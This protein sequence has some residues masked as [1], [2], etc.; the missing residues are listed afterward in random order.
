MLNIPTR[1]LNQNATLTRRSRSN[2]AFASE[3]STG[4]AK[5]Q[6]RLDRRKNKD[7]RHQQIPVFFNR[8]LRGL[9]RRKSPLTRSSNADLGAIIG[10]Y[11]NTVA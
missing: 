8:R 7:R 1:Q 5:I 4:S 9:H 6:R 2:K 10:K 11:V 3:D